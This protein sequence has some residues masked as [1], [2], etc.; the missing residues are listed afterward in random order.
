[1]LLAPKHT[2]YVAQFA[3]SGQQVNETVM[4]IEGQVQEGG[5][6]VVKICVFPMIRVLS[7]ELNN[8]DAANG[9]P[10]I[11]YQN[12]GL[13]KT[14]EEVNKELLQKALVLA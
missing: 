4:D 14:H 10:V 5:G 11:S 2:E 6:N 8:A 9:K 13:A 3:G 1:M 7:P 12:L